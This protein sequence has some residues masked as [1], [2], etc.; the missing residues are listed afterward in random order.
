MG[1]A[2]RTRLRNP[3]IQKSR[4]THCTCVSA[5]IVLWPAIVSCPDLL[6]FLQCPASVVVFFHLKSAMWKFPKTWFSCSF[7][8]KEYVSLFAQFISCQE[9]RVHFGGHVHVGKMPP[10]I[11]EDDFSY[12]AL[13]PQLR[14]SVFFFPLSKEFGVSNIKLIYHQYMPRS[15]AQGW[16][17]KGHPF[18]WE[19]LVCWAFVST[20]HNENIFK[21]FMQSPDM[22]FAEP[23]RPRLPLR[24]M[25]C[26]EWEL[27]R[28]TIPSH[29]LIP[30]RF[31]ICDLN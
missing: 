6:F 27:Q 29:I 4:D 13:P 28:Y 8:L 15:W 26:P 3:E 9:T 20:Y 5:T 11:V 10:K 21:Y 16:A 31:V 7:F 22:T 19:S 14:S 12:Q 23:Q 18:R 2:L 24:L 30:Y 1:V 17:G 25:S